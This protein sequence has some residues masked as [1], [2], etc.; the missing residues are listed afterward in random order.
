MDMDMNRIESV[1]LLKDA[2]AK[3][4]YGSKAANGVVVITTR[5]LAGNEQRVTY[6]GSVD[7]QMPDLSSY[8]LCDAEEKLEA[9]RIDGIYDDA[10][11]LLYTQK[12][13]LYQQRKQLVAAGLDTIGYRNLCVRVWGTN[14][15]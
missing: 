14:T 1:T 15:T 9:E 8:N 2:S 12:Q 6:T 11:F 4:I 5:R 3:A 13:M 10:N 7:I